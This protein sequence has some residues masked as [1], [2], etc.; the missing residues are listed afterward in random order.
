MNDR[1]IPFSDLAP[2]TAEIRAEVE[3][4]WRRLLDGNAWV[5]GAPVER[6]ERAFASYCDTAEAVAV[7]NGTDALHLILRAL[8]IGPGDE[9]LV[10][11]NT[12]IATA[13]AVV[14]AGARPRFV[15]VDPTSLLMTPQGAEAALTPSTA[16]IVPVHLFGHVA[17][18]EGLAEVARR[19]G[20]ALVEDAAQAQ[21]AERNGVRAGSTGRAAGFSFYPGKNLGAFGDA[22]AV[23]TDDAALAATIRSL[24]DHGRAADDK[25]L[26]TSVGTNS[27][28]DA[29]Q[30]VVLSAK[31]ARLDAW[32]QRRAK[33]VDAYRERLADLPLRIVE[34]DVGVDSAWHLLVVRVADRDAVRAGLAER[35]VLTGIHYPVPCH[36]QPAFAA[37]ADG[38]LPCASEAAR[39]ILSLPLHPYMDLEDVDVVRDALA[40]VL[41][42]RRGPT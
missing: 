3:D 12:F 27:R 17:D 42:R 39:E 6:F 7:A 32:T 36:E 21:G 35:G 40:D 19:H 23:T 30:A 16:A 4:G 38:P 10:P 11:A 34:P 20:L 2:T 24:A 15:D 13:E 1:V 25:F 41:R 18:V 33:I 22:G 14:L 29:V 28:L 37:W 31:L 9:V 5:G 8:G 26:H